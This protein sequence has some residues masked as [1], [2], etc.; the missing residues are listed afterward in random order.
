MEGSL[1]SQLYGILLLHAR[2]ESLVIRDIAATL[3]NK[4][5]SSSVLFMHDTMELDLW[6]QAIPRT[7]RGDNAMTQD[8]VPLSDEVTAVLGFLDDCIQRCSKTPYKYLE[9]LRVLFRKTEGND[10]D[11]AVLPSPL[12]VTVL[13]QLEA[14]IRAKLLTPSDTLALITFT[15]KL[16]IGLSTKLSNLNDTRIIQQKFEDLISKSTVISDSTIIQAGLQRECTLL[17]DIISFIENPISQPVH[18]ESTIKSLHLLD[19]DC[20]SHIKSTRKG[21]KPD[22]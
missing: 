5:L 7:K 10:V 11:F 22:F 16:A 1:H 12:L 15:R 4:V 13:E 6:L 18:G 9:D 14:K 8:G 2:S 3:S 19:S 17:S 20:K 21:K